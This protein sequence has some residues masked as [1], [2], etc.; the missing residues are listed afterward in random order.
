MSVNTWHILT[1]FIPILLRM[2]FLNNSMIVF[3]SIISNLK[4]HIS[5][6]EIG[7]RSDAYMNFVSIFLCAGVKYFAIFIWPHTYFEFKTF[8]CLIFQSKSFFITNAIYS[9]KALCFYR[10][11]HP[12]LCKG[13]TQFKQFVNIL[14]SSN[15]DF[16]NVVRNLLSKI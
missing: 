2:K 9:L 11:H 6:G 4:L 12:K 10:L 15:S 3:Y 5:L 16:N 8:L 14:A 1:H 13:W 7:L